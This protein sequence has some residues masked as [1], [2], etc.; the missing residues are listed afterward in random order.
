MRKIA[1]V[2]GVVCVSGIIIFSVRGNKDEDAKMREIVARAIKA[3]GGDNLEKFKGSISK[4]KGK[5]LDLEYTTESTLQLPDRSRTVAE[6]KLGKFVQ[7]LNGDKGWIKLGDLSR[8]CVKEELDEMREQFNAMQIS[9]LAVLTDKEYKLSPLGEEKIDERPAIG[10]HVEHK[11][12]RD[13]NLYFDK[14]NS[15]L[16]KMET[17]I[18]DPLRGGEEIAAETLYGDYKDVDGVMTAFKVTIKYDGKV[19]IDSEVTEM[20]YAERIDDSYFDKP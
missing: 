14:E 5:L 15:L 7:V 13:I 12:F 11:G 19:Y 3:H 17:R 18:K 10:M 20:K 2:V 8:E 1:G 9:H 16:L 6:S 4:S